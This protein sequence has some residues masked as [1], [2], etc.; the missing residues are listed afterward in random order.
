MRRIPSQKLSL[1]ICGVEHILHAKEGMLGMGNNIKNMSEVFR[2]L[3][4]DT[5][6]RLLG[7]FVKRDLDLCV[8]EMVSALGLPQYQV[9]RHLSVLRRAGFLRSVKKGT[10]A[11]Y[12]LVREEPFILGLLELLERTLPE[13]V[14][15][16]DRK[17]M[18][19]R[20][21]LRARGECVV[22][23]VNVDEINRLIGKENQ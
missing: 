9:S 7:L 16:E 15:E 2:A 17:R 20:L 4:D 5:R 18:D 22:G 3:G 8:C 10:W 19:A 12:S 23:S 13:N 11:Y 1:T 6:L 21:A 14:F